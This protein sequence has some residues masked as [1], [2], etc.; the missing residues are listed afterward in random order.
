[1]DELDIIF[2]PWRYTKNQVLRYIIAYI[3]FAVVI[4]TILG[5]LR[6]SSYMND[7]SDFFKYRAFKKTPPSKPYYTISIFKFFYRLIF[8]VCIILSWIYFMPIV[9]M[10]I[11]G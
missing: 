2:D 1:M 5:T 4:W 8:I 7:F 11:N 3:A 9:W 10:V 6:L